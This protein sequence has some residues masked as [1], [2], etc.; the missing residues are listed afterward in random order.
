MKD[1]N[2]YLI[3]GFAAISTEL[4]GL[5]YTVEIRDEHAAKRMRALAENLNKQIVALRE[6]LDERS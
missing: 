3:D 6:R 5:A 1:E 2:H 4:S